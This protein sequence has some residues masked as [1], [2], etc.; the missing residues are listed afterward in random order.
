MG[1]DIHMH[2][3][4]KLN[5][6]WEC[7]GS[8]NVSRNYQLFGKM[9]GVRGVETSIADPKGLPKDCSTVVK[10][11]ADYWG[12]G[13]HSHSYLIATEIVELEKWWDEEYKDAGWPQRYPESQWGYLLGN[14]WGGFIKYPEDRPEGIEDVRFVFW[15]DN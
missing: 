12:S 3:E 14:S 6:Q 1:C 11:C 2:T 10:F 8:P 13:G 4:V 15:F 5:G 9:A 7:F